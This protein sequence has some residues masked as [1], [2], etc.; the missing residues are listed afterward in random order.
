[1]DEYCKACV[2]GTDY[3]CERHAS[4]DDLEKMLN[5]VLDAHYGVATHHIGDGDGISPEMA[6]KI[7]VYWRKHLTEAGWGAYLGE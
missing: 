1:M 3:L 2:P 7:K 5:E 4:V 6:E